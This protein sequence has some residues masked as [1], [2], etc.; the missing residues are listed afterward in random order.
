MIADVS[1][2]QGREA[3]E[4]LRAGGG[5]AHYVHADVSKNAE[6]ESLIAETVSTFGALDYAFNNAGI[7]AAFGVDFADAAEDEWDRLI[8]VNLKGVWLCM[9]YE[10]LQMLKQGCGSIVN[11]AS[12]AGLKGT[13][14]KAK[15]N[16]PYLIGPDGA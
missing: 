7:M 13:Y 11:T 6:V 10:I 4:A 16:G 9:K 1:D 5:K 14:L 2:T 8:A 12:V 15:T 3:V